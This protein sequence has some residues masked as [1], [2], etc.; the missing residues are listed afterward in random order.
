MES[1]EYSRELWVP[2]KILEQF[3]EVSR[4]SMEFQKQLE[5]P[6]TPEH[7][8]KVPKALGELRVL[9]RSS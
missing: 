8:K 9:L 6:K 4:T 5:V 2:L 7:T 1:N 3:W